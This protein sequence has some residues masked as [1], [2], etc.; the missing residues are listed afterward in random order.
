MLLGRY[1]SFELSIS[2]SLSP[3]WL[4]DQPVSETFIV[5]Q[6][7]RHRTE[8][9]KRRQCYLTAGKTKRNGRGVEWRGG[10]EGRRMKRDRLQLWSQYWVQ[11]L[12]RW[13]LGDLGARGRGKKWINGWLP[14]VLWTAR[15]PLKYAQIDAGFISLSL[16]YLQIVFCPTGFHSLEHRTLPFHF[17]NKRLEYSPDGVNVIHW[18][19]RR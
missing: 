16:F 6:P 8:T 5:N 17:V 1:T 11:L 14:T 12:P 19:I 13:D 10:H 2:R 7:F 15:P 3:L 4:V 18:K 9:I